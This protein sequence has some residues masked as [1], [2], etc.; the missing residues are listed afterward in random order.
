MFTYQHRHK[1]N[2]NFEILS[3][4]SVHVM[5]KCEKKKK[6]KKKKTFPFRGLWL[7]I[8][9]FGS[10]IEY[11]VDFR[12]DS[13]VVHVYDVSN[14]WSFCHVFSAVLVFYVDIALRSLS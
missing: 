10:V 12:V 6:K 14:E 1:H 11:N 3:Y 5:A 7:K 2:L 13:A 4:R 9:D 8:I